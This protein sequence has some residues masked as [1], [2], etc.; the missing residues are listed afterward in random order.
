M[1]SLLIFTISSTVV[2]LALCFALLQWLAIGDTVTG[3]AKKA[4]RLFS[5]CF[6]LYATGQSWVIFQVLKALPFSNIPNYLYAAAAILFAVGSY[7]QLK[8]IQK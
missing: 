8:S 6:M 7:Y 1:D 4:A 2:V 5:L 3:P